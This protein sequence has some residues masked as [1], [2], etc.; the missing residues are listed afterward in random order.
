MPRTI[1]GVR[2]ALAR[3]RRGEERRV[4]LDDQRAFRMNRRTGERRR[5][6]DGAQRAPSITGGEVEEM[7]ASIEDDMIIEITDL[8][9]ELINSIEPGELTQIIEL[10]AEPG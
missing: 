7:F 5:Q 9:D 2:T 6:R 1:A 3:E 10:V 8:D 4:G